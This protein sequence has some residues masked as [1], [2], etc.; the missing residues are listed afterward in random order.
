MIKEKPYMKDK[1]VLLVS[2]LELERKTSFTRQLSLLASAFEERGLRALLA[3]HLSFNKRGQ[4]PV[5]KDI[6][7]RS[8]KDIHFLIHK[9]GAQAAILLGYPD[10]FPFLNNISNTASGKLLDGYGCPAI[11]FFLWSQ[12]SRPPAEGSLDCLIPV[13]LTE[14]TRSFIKSSGYK[15]PGPVIP[16]GV[17][18]SY[19][20]PSNEA[21]RKKGKF[22][23][24]LKNR[25]V[26]GSVG[27]NTSRKR[28][29]SIIESFA[30]FYKQRPDGFLLIKTD[31]LI[32]LDGTDLKEHAQKQGV[33]EAVKFIQDDLSESRMRTLYNM[34][35]LYINLSEWEGFCIPAIEAMACGVP[36]ATQPIQGP[37]EIVPYQDLIIPESS[38]IKEE[39]R[40]VLRASPDAT[41]S[42]MLSVSTN[43]AL[44]KNLGA[45]GR[46]E[47][48]NNY[49]IRVA[50]GLWEKLF[51]QYP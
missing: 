28:F 51:N 43:T 42:L 14:T 32:S 21:E 2:G 20:Y 19:Y 5:L 31:R 35:D 24:G 40:V 48:V 49:D 44:L 9:T 27:A 18:T 4:E 29:K 34:M 12:F 1:T 17:D 46:T 10:Q 37:S 3:S 33:L 30:C 6:L 39:G 26:I 15:T 11:P 38:I 16:H 45:E 47:A 25:F 22:K 7:G 41:A 36:V 8:Y 23:L 13:P 50:A